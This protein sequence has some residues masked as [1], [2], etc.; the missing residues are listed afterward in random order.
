MLE[1]Q[2]KTWKTQIGLH[3]HILSFYLASHAQP[4]PACHL[5]Q[6]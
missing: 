2:G 5:S 1:L 6:I 3:F 4:S